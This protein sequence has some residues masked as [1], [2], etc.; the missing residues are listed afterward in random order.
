M[1]IF[2]L[3]DFNHRRSA[4][5]KVPRSRCTYIAKFGGKLAARRA[6]VHVFEGKHDTRPVVMFE[7]PSMNAI[8]AFWN[9]SDYPAIKKIRKGVAT[10]NAWAFP[11]V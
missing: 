1:T 8:H 3:T 2:H 11:G 10:P 7:F 9:S 6:K 4:I 5:S